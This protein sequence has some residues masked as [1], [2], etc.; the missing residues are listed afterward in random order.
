VNVTETSTQSRSPYAA[1]TRDI[2]VTVQPY[3]L[4]EQS[5]PDAGHYV[6]AYHVRIQN[7]GVQTVQLLTRHWMITDAQG[8]VQEVRG[9]GVVG[10]Q[11]V[12]GPGDAFE[13]ASGTP[14]ATPS[15]I[16]VGT[17]QMEAADTGERFDIAIPAFSLDSPHH[18]VVVN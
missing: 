7:D 3:F 4:E 17:Y 15:G 13:Y 6:W 9:V 12:L 8:H 14:L 18:R 16:M 10:K 2:T 1:T 11:P 5:V